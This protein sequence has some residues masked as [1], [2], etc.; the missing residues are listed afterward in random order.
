MDVYQ[1][2][3]NVVYSFIYVVYIIE[4]RY[5]TDITT[6]SAAIDS[7]NCHTINATKYI[8]KYTTNKTTN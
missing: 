8:S 5:C 1:Q 4:F 7:T 3:K 2:K 6:V